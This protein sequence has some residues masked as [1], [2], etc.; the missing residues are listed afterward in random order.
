MAMASVEDG[1]LS[2]FES[3]QQ[4]TDGTCIEVED[5]CSGARTEISGSATV[6]QKENPKDKGMTKRDR[7]ALANGVRG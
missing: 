3:P 1:D 5:T 7:S 6:K 4:S 2:C